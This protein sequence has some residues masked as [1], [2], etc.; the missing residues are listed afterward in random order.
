MSNFAGIRKSNFLPQGG[1][2]VQ[3]TVDTAP[4]ERKL[5]LQGKVEHPNTDGK[6]QDLARIIR[7]FYMSL[8]KDPRLLTTA[9]KQALYEQI[10]AALGTEQ[11]LTEYG[12]K[13]ARLLAGL[14]SPG[15]QVES[16]PTQ[17]GKSELNELMRETRERIQKLAKQIEAIAANRQQ[18][19]APS[20]RFVVTKGAGSE[21]TASVELRMALQN[22]KPAFPR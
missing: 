2:D 12:K 21:E 10:V 11:A 19:P 5:D 16:G 17:L 9:E 15:D 8:P 3:K 18:T 20:A 4:A 1:S 13:L 7:S 22:G 6:V 14:D